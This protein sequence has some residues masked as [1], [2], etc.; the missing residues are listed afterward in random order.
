LLFNNIFVVTCFFIIHS[1]ERTTYEICFRKLISKTISILK[2]R[3]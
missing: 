1:F 2:S 3:F